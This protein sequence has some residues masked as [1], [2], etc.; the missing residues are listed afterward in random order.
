MALDATDASPQVLRGY[1][2]QRL[3]RR[4]DAASDFSQALSQPTL[5]TAGQRQ[6]RLIAADAALAA[7]DPLAA[8]ALLKDIPP[9][10]GELA[11]EQVAQRRR[12]AT[13]ALG[14]RSAPESAASTTGAVRPRQNRL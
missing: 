11:D 3:D 8:L 7:Q 2:R 13:A 4:A 6:V 14:G 12:T 9:G 1:A 10:A 5:G